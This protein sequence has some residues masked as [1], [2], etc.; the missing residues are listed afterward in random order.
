MEVGVGVGVGV[1]AAVVVVVV[2][3]GASPLPTT[4]PN[5]CQEHIHFTRCLE[6]SC[7]VVV[8]C[9]S[10]CCCLRGGGWVRGGGA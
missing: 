4:S 2:I 1:G 6:Y 3:V 9:Q 8:Q 7:D 5:Y 10:D